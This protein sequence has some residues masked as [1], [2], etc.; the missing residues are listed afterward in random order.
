MVNVYVLIDGADSPPDGWSE[1]DADYQDRM[2]LMGGALSTGGSDT[3]THTGRAT[4]NSVATDQNRHYAASTPYA[5]VGAHS[6]G[7]TLTSIGSPNHL[8]PYKNFRVF[9]RSVTGWDGKVPSGAIVFNPSVPGGWARLDASDSYFVRISATAGGTGGSATPG[10]HTVAGAVSALAQSNVYNG[11]STGPVATTTH[12]HGSY[13]DTTDAHSDPDWKYWAAGL[14]KAA[15]E[16]FLAAGC[17]LLFDGDPGAKWELV[18]NSDRYLR[19][20]G[21][22]PDVATGG[23][24]TTYTHGHSKDITSGAASALTTVNNTPNTFATVGAH[25]HTITVTLDNAAAQPAYVKF[26]LYKLIS[27]FG[28][29]IGPQLIGLP[30]F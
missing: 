24:N 25:T 27:N 6:H 16:I 21:P 1:I 20:N 4:T 9:Y 26:F 7:A 10:G 3:H 12:N 23:A 14:V 13:S 11:V 19:H 2:P 15:A 22:S 17:Y 18:S 29:G 5:L 28:G 8:P 30:F